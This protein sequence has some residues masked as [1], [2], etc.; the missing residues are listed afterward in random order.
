MKT[1]LAYP[2]GLAVLT[3]LVLLAWG[4]DRTTAVVI[5]SEDFEDGA[6]DG[7]TNVVD[8]TGAPDLWHVTSNFPSSGAYTLGYV[9]NE[10]L[11]SST[12][13]GDYDTP[14]LDVIA[15]TFSL[16]ITIPADHYATLT[17]DAFVGDEQPPGGGGG[18]IN[19]YEFDQFSLWASLD[20]STLYGPSALASSAPSAGGVAIPEW[21]GPGTAAYH[22][23]TLDLSA[24]AGQSIYLAYR[25][26]SIDDLWNGYPG[27][28]ID[29]IKVDAILGAPTF[30]LVGVGLVV[31]GI[32]RR[33]LR[34]GT[35]AGALR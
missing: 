23:L 25:F 28:R 4:L 13:D 31:I 27:V 32:F 8:P 9:K 14:G 26:D 17:F 30:L 20:G 10:T 15:T 34:P 1:V 33:K 35:H 18:D 5:Y 24:F 29:N 21:G 2:W 12:P 11:N 16:A 19:P 7:F 22:T 6:A 3:I